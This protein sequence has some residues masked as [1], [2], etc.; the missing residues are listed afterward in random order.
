MTILGPALCIADQPANVPGIQVSLLGLDLPVHFLIHHLHLGFHKSSIEVL[1]VKFMRRSSA[2]R[3]LGWGQPGHFLFNLSGLVEDLG[4]IL[5]GR[6][7]QCNIGLQVLVTHGRV[8][9]A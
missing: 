4:S 6:L 8:R 3:K 5:Q 2:K 7:N 1:F 9:I